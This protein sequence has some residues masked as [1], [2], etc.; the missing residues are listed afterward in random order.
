MCTNSFFLV[1]SVKFLFSKFMIVRNVFQLLLILLLGNLNLSKHVSLQRF[2][3]SKHVLAEGESL[4]KIN[5][6]QFYRAEKEVYVFPR[7]TNF[8]PS[9][10]IHEYISGELKK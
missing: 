7:L 5:T 2:C 10:F 6:I 4:I 8:F 1:F 9:R 3:F